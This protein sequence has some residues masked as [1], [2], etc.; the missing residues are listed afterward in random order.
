MGLT[1]H[2]KVKKMLDA[3]K[4]YRKD[5]GYNLEWRRYYNYYIGKHWKKNL[6]ASHPGIVM[7][8]CMNMIESVLS[9][10]LKQAPT[11][12]VVALGDEPEA[13]QACES[14]TAAF[15]S[16]S[17][18][19]DFQRTLRLGGRNRYIYGTN[20]L[21]VWWDKNRKEEQ[22]EFVIDAVSPFAIFHDPFANDVSDAEFIIQGKRM[23]VERLNRL[24]KAKLTETDDVSQ[25]LRPGDYKEPE[26]GTL[27]YEAWIEGG[28]RV[29]MFTDD[30]IIRDLEN[31]YEHQQMP[32]I[33]DVDVEIPDEYEGIGMIEPIITLQREINERRSQGVIYS[34][35]HTW[36]WI[37]AESGAVKHIER[38][39]AEANQIIQVQPGMN[40]RREWAP[41]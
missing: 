32:F 18:E 3:G 34:R 17:E 25:E 21:K 16:W 28:K 12:Y 4:Q 14:Y 6:P 30:K 31:P 10:L 1:L 15:A 39:T 2:Q 36:P 26:G 24:G 41:V 38:M 9:A 13:A 33:R 40:I 20:H 27:V 8:V 11:A 22:G 5:K 29:V 35:F 23:S 37:I 19:E 7:N